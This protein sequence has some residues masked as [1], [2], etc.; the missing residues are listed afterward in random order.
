MKK[1]PCDATVVHQQKR[2]IS[3]KWHANTSQC[4]Q[5][6][7]NA[8]QS[9]VKC[10]PLACDGQTFLCR[11]IFPDTRNKNTL[12]TSLNPVS[13]AALQEGAALSMIGPVILVSGTPRRKQH[14]WKT[15]LNENKDFSECG[16]CPAAKIW[17]A[18]C[19]MMSICV[20]SHSSTE[21]VFKC[22]SPWS[23][24]KPTLQ[25]SSV[26]ASLHEAFVLSCCSPELVW[27]WGNRSA[28][29]PLCLILQG[30]LVDIITLCKIEYYP[31]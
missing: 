15:V 12:I 14:L 29:S 20:M 6:N 8:V 1:K 16:K 4:S 18:A 27:A 5:T 13:V 11:N 25:P 19:L 7:T 26:T 17:P 23:R 28:V 22:V 9:N 3:D 24:M 30:R 10:K 2:V 21:M 31:R